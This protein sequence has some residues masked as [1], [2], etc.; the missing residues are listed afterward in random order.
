MQSWIFTG[1]GGAAAA[2][3]T[4]SSLDKVLTRTQGGI[5]VT[6]TGTNLTGATG[7]AIG[8]LALTS[9][10]ALTATTVQ[11]L[12]AATGTGTYTA[13]VTTPAGTSAGGGSIKF[14]NPTSIFGANLRRWY[15]QSYAA[16]V[17]TDESSTAN[18]SQGTA[19][20][21][22]ASSTIAGTTHRPATHVALD[23][24][25]V[26]DALNS[27]GDVELFTTAGTVACIIATAT[28]GTD[29]IAVGK[30][31]G[32]EPY[33]L[34]SARA[35]AADKC[36]FGVGGSTDTELAV[37]AGALNDN[38]PHRLIGTYAVPASTLYVDGTTAAADTG[39]FAVGVPDTGDLVSIGGAMTS[40]A[41]TD[42]HWTGKIAEVVIANV[43]ASST[44]RDELDAYLRDCAGA[45]T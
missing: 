38:N 36:A 2:L 21:R 11:G 29:A 42:Y 26:D 23:F 7:A 8:G 14:V 25:G 3:P 12:T 34:G 30:T 33:Q 22:P 45:A 20:K 35:V 4:V 5:L 10:V 31:Y 27:G 24:D 37:S 13:T 18:T 32:G 43:A 16:G 40:E 1:K 44:Q 19:G 6:I 15:S 41:T 39:T 9:F 17:W 28:I